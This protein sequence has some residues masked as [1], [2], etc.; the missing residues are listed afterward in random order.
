MAK[1]QKR[2]LKLKQKSLN[3]RNRVVNNR[4]KKSKSKKRMRGGFIRAGSVQHF[5]CANCEKKIEG[6]K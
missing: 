6:P 1:I 4:N 5:Y 2:S 3:K